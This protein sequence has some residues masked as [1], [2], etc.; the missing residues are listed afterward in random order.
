[1]NPEAFIRK[2]IITALVAEGFSEV[3]AGGGGRTR[4]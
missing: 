3:V 2:H 4:H 1:M